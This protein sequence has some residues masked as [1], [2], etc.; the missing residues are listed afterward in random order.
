[1]LGLISLVLVT[2]LYF[3]VI[4]EKDIKKLIDEWKTSIT[5]IVKSDE[6]KKLSSKVW[7]DLKKLGVNSWNAVN[8]EENKKKALEAI[9]KE[10]GITDENKAQEL[11]KAMM[12][13]NK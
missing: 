4:W 3:G 2:L 13:Q 8:T 11:L 10:T 1:M 12:E 5:E 6:F 9:K 7:E